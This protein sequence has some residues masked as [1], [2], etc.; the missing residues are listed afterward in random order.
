MIRLMLIASIVL[1]LGS[2]FLAYQTR[3]RGGV[4]IEDRDASQKRAKTVEEQLTKEKA[5]KKELETKL[6]T[7]E[8]QSGELKATVEK[9]KADLAQTKDESVKLEGRIKEKEVELE[10][11]KSEMSKPKVVEN[12][13]VSAQWE[14]KLADLRGQLEKSNL[15]AQEQERRAEELTKKIAELQKKKEEEVKRAVVKKQE[16]IKNTVGRILAYDPDWNFVVVDIG[17]KNGVTPAS[18]LNVMRKGSPVAKLKITKVQPETV[19]AGVVA[20][21]SGKFVKLEA[22]DTVVFADGGAAAAAL[23]GAASLDAAKVP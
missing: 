13:E 12:N 4:V 1:S 21:K 2:A 17:D 9:S 5:Q 23:V 18:D 20:L 8:K 22:E 14:A 6:Q 3:V 19:T 7:S 15:A 10:R 16:V 11:V